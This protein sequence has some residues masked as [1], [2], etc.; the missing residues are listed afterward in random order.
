MEQNLVSIIILNYNGQKFLKNC[1]DSIKL[2]TKKKYEIIVVD[3]A[4]PDNSGR[5]NAAIYLDCK[6]ILNEKNEGVPE[7]LNIGI[8]N[9]NGEF[10]ILMNNDVTVT[11]N[12]LEEFFDAYK[13]YGLALYQPKFVKMT[14]P[15]ILDGTG[16]MINLFGFGFARGKGQMDK[17]DYESFEE[18]SYSSGTCMFLPKKIIDEIG[19]FDKKLFAYHEEL[20]FG[21]RARLCGYK[22]YYV[23]KSV[24]HHYGSAGWGW[25]GKKF[26]FLER[27]RWIVLLKNYSLKTIL[28]LLPSLFLIEIIMLGF[29]AKKGILGK[30]ISSYGS[31]IKSYNEIV[32]NRKNI[33]K[34]RKLSDDEILKNFCCNIYIPPESE[35]GQHVRNFNRILIKLAKISGFYKKVR[36]VE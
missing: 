35:E 27:N 33:Q 7:G 19:L 25:S 17:G 8:K 31:I 21:W 1:I 11:E 34:M 5:E 22:S 20:D 28:Q 6:F 4:S 2:V 23:P 9:A 16:D 13:K 36:I 15:K 29:F 14:N 30:K 18:I 32:A 3:N 10:I 12:W 24:I 26:Y